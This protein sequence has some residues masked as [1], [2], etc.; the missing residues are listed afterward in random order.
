MLV[1]SIGDCMTPFT[2]VGSGSP[3]ASRIVG[4]MSMTL[5]SDSTQYHHAGR[6][7]RT[8]MLQVKVVDQGDSS[9]RAGA[10]DERI[11]E[12]L[13]PNEPLSVVGWRTGFQERAARID[14]TETSSGV[15]FQHVGGVYRITLIPLGLPA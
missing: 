5:A 12:L 1:P 2:I 4:A 9:K 6:A 3:A 13:H 7:A 10:A 8:F 14:F 11:E 15:K